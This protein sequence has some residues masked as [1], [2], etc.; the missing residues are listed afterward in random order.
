MTYFM[1]WWEQVSGAT[2]GLMQ[3]GLN[4][5]VIL[6]AWMIWNHR[7]RCVFDNL[8][9]NLAVVLRLARDE[10][11]MWEM[12]G[13]KGLVLLSAVSQILSAAIS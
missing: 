11:K 3:Q 9:P 12:A 5:L 7:N 2:R 1:A 4:S 13:T 8:A 10:C 6:G